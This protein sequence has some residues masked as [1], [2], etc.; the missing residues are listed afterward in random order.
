MLDALVDRQNRHVA[1]AS[2][3]SGVEDRLKGRQH[4]DRSIGRKVNPIDDIGTGQMKRLFGNRLALV[5]EK[6][7]V[8]SENRFKSR[9]PG[10]ALFKSAD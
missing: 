3:T 2:E 10:N 1:S 4:P 5:L 7:C 8:A 6:R 9:K